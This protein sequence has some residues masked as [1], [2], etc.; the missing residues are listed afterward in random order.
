MLDEA[1]LAKQSLQ[2]GPGV[3]ESMAVQKIHSSLVIGPQGEQTRPD[4]KVRPDGLQR[5]AQRDSQVNFDIE[6]PDKIEEK[7]LSGIDVDKQE[8]CAILIN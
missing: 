1:G 2:F 8:S 5:G 3:S 6:L 4:T 7:D